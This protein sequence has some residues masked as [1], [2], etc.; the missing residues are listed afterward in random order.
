MTSTLFISL[1]VLLLLGVP[2]GVALGLSTLVG[3]WLHFAGSGME[4]ML[5]QAFVTTADSFPLMA[6]P[7]FILVGTLMEKGGLARRITNAAGALVGHIPGGLGASALLA[8]AI[9]SAISGSGPGVTAAVGAL[10]IPAM[11]AQGYGR[12]YSAALV[13]AGGVVGPIIPPSIPMIIYGVTVGASAVAMFIGGVI[14]GLLII[15]VL[16]LYNYFISL[17]RGYRG[18]EARVPAAEVRAALR[19]AFPALVM[20]V[21]VLG[22]IYGGVFTPTESAVVGVVYALLAGLFLY[23]ELTW[24]KIREA[25]ID[26][27]LLTAIVMIL[28]G[29][30]T[31]FGRFLTI[32]RVPDKLAT[33]MLGFS[34]SPFVIMMLVMGFLLVAGMFI[35]TTSNIV[36]FAPLLAPIAAKMGLSLEYFGILMVVNLCIGFLTPPVGMNLFV[37]QGVAGESLEAIVKEVLV[38]LALLTAVLVLL[39][40]FPGIVTFLPK[41]LGF[42]R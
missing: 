25:M 17:R 24:A 7:L 3:V 2:I 37:A 38:P 41:Y 32:D 31:T 8:A 5:A 36:L 14:P 15:G 28:L 21:M 30:A 23:R 42:L 27:A 6:V 13:A 20:P 12:A 29:G 1:A 18:I 11:A 22:G 35:D 19:E 40:A 39:V 10:M 16:A 34:T 33:W 9:F 26:A 4:R